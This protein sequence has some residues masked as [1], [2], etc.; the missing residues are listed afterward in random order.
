[1]LKYQQ[2]PTFQERSVCLKRGKDYKTEMLK[3]AQTDIELQQEILKMYENANIPVP[4]RY[5]TNQ[6]EGENNA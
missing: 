3:E 5:K 6:T 2:K 4:E 1:V